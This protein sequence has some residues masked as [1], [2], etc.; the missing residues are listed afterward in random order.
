MLLIALTMLLLALTV[1]VHK[2]LTTNNYAT[3]KASPHLGLRHADEHAPRGL[4][5]GA[6][7]VHVV[8]REVVEKLLE[9]YEE[10]AGR[11]QAELGQLCKVARVAHLSGFF[12]LWLE[13]GVGKCERRCGQV[14]MEVGVNAG[15]RAQ[16]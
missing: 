3:T 11:N 2:V 7:G 4:H 10:G 8:V 15:E 13:A 9:S 16:V 6:R 14:W 12:N 5:H 1:V